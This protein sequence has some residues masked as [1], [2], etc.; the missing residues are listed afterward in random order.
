MADFSLLIK[1]ASGDCNLRCRYCFYLPKRELF[2]PGAHRMSAKVLEA[3]TRKFLSQPM[4]L[5]SFG[6]QGGEPTLMG[7]D[8][9]QQAR[10][11]Q[12][13]HGRA[14]GRIANA[15]QTNGT[16]LDAAWGRFLAQE[17]FLVGISIDGPAELHDQ[18]RVYGDGRGSHAEVMRGLAVLREHRVEHN[19]LT[20]VSHANEDHAETVYNYLGELGVTYQQY[21][22]CVE[23]AP[24][25]QRRPYALSPG[26]WGEFLCRIFDLWY[27]QDTRRVSIR[28]FDSILSRLLTGVPTI[29]SMSGDC[30]NYFVIEHNCEVY[31]CDFQ[32][33][34]ELRLGNILT[35]DFAALQ[36][37]EKYRRWGRKKNPHSATCEAC[38]FLPLCMGDCPK[39]RRRGQSYLCEDWQ[40]FYQH[41]IGRFEELAAALGAEWQ[42][43]NVQ[44]WPHSQK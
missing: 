30:R 21:I 23:F 37:L 7:V 31:P 12:R 4:S 33:R 13:R 5:H 9:F 15:L 18:S 2:G 28:L 3:M 41:S 6:W 39:N 26:K 8:F 10:A 22:E 40:L 29:C 34:P 38:R 44:K 14:G 17:Q 1:P 43:K 25:G 36:K 24:D 19:V 16:L 20:L 32:V 35:T 27:P 42:A 11:C